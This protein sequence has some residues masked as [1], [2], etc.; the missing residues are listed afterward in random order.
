[1]TRLTAALRFAL[2]CVAGILVA[3]CGG[4]ES[5]SGATAS[6]SQ[7]AKSLAVEN[8][9]SATV[10]GL[11]KVSETR[12]TRTVF[13]YGFR[14]TVKNDGSARNGVLARLSSVGTGTSIVVGEVNVGD[15]GPDATATS[16]ETVVVRHDRAYPFDPSKFQWLLASR[17]DLSDLEV[18][19]VTIDGADPTQVLRIAG[20]D[21]GGTVDVISTSG[22]QPPE[23]VEV[24]ISVGADRAHLTK[25]SPSWTLSVGGANLVAGANLNLELRI[26]SPAAGRYALVPVSVAAVAPSYLARG[27]IYPVSG[28]TLATSSGHL[29]KFSGGTL[30]EPVEATLTEAKLPGGARQFAIQFNRNPS[31]AHVTVTFP[32]WS[33][34]PTVTALGERSGLLRR[35]QDIALASSSC[36]SDLPVPYS[37]SKDSLGAGGPWKSF[38]AATIDSRS[39]LRLRTA[40]QQ[41]DLL[42]SPPLTG[43]AGSTPMLAFKGDKPSA[44]LHS[45][46]PL[47]SCDPGE[48]DVV[49]FVHGYEPEIFGLGGGYGTWGEFPR[50]AMNS[51]RFSGKS[52]IPFEFRWRTN[53]SFS[54]VAT[55][56]AASINLIR[57]ALGLKPK[58][59]IVAHSFG[60]LV[61]R[62]LL[63]GHATNDA[64][65]P[66]ETAID[67]VSSLLTLGTPHSG[68]ASEPSGVLPKGNDNRLL[69]RCKQVSC[70]EA[71]LA[72]AL[73]KP[74]LETLYGAA[75]PPAGFVPLFISMTTF[76][77]RT[78]PKLKV[79]SGIGLRK[80]SDSSSAG[81][82]L[83]TY[84]GQRFKP[85]FR[86][87]EAL[88]AGA[89][90]LLGADVTEVILGVRAFKGPGIPA[91]DEV[92]AN[93]RRGYA[94]TR[95]VVLPDLGDDGEIFGFD[96]FGWG[97]EAR[98][99]GGCTSDDDAH[100]DHA[101]LLLLQELITGGGPSISRS[102][103]LTV[104]GRHG[105]ALAPD[106][107]K[108]WG[109]NVSGQLGDG[110][111]TDKSTP[112][113]VVGLSSA[114]SISAANTWTCV[115]TSSG[116]IKCWGQNDYGQ[117]GDGTVTNKS[118]PQDVPGMTG[119]VAI[120]GGVFHTCAV[121]TL[122]GVKC[123]GRSSEGQLGNPGSAAKQTSPIDVIGLTGGVASIAAG[124][125]H[126][127]AL[128]ALG[129]VKCWGLNDFGQLGN[130]SMVNAAAPV[131]V[132]GL[133][134]GVAAIASG[135][136]NTCALMTSG[137]VKCWGRN[138][139][140]QL[141]NPAASDRQLTAI[142]VTGLGASVIALAGGGLGEHTCA[143]TSLGGAKCW[144][145]NEQGQ[146]GDG[147][148]SNRRTPV[149]VVGLASD[150][151]SVSA[152]GLTTCAQL[153]L[154]AVKCWGYGGHG[155]LGNGATGNSTVPVN[156]SG[157]GP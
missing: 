151:A 90:D 5:S 25:D 31:G 32:D 129:G 69:L 3:G 121:T 19:T 144:G 103:T 110:T 24:S 67:S 54:D 138:V 85:A 60:G 42:L 127:C 21:Y 81:D 99:I 15:I 12:V 112:V 27:V 64:T 142:D 88:I 102:A 52:L 22:A 39:E 7:R 91:F 50:L 157:F 113:A 48:S 77:K 35:A 123:W 6:Q 56:L 100:C 59:H 40:P 96:T 148:T 95:A 131:D 58:I 130:G 38:I 11:M 107:V 118:T 89:T 33:A 150:V 87:T 86:Q 55:D 97:F 47:Q 132:V 137:G 71:G 14:V 108:C 153:K 62:S 126:T 124:G 79:I 101:S 140:G 116:G 145:Y 75:P 73:K 37:R 53:A 141:G 143:L 61:A 146:L 105:C 17:G 82:H 136:Y 76:Q 30:A 8:S 104:G 139:E 125:F 72:D 84:E 83:I 41:V 45:V 28:G 34:A 1:M 23:G 154:G 134:A 119:V 94:H 44:E 29:V 156:V 20:I 80:D 46:L 2:A 70:Y 9:R 98:V 115:L 111:T 4:G 106:G 147:T 152:G 51:S 155:E 26:L 93:R 117:L 36:P 43:T 114:V 16:T 10:I 66:T 92:P 65:V 74:Q 149:D 13:E 120:G 133:S 122:G 78:L 49:I 135:Q 18:A 57:S 109:W 128:T 63:Q 68:I